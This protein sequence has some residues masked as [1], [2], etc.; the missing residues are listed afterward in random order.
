MDHPDKPGDD[1]FWMAAFSFVFIRV[2]SWSKKQ[3]TPGASS[4][5][6]DF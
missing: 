4:A 3:K 5:S 6:G 1:D 2:H